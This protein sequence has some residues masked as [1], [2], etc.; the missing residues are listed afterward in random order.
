VTKWRIRD[1]RDPVL[2]APTKPVT[3]DDDINDL[4]EEMLKRV[5]GRRCVGIAANQLGVPLRTCVVFVEGRALLMINP[6]IVAKSADEEPADEGCLS[7]DGV[8]VTVYRPVSVRVRYEFAG[9]TREEDF[10]GF[11]ARVIQHEVDHLDGVVMTDRVSRS[12]R[13]RLEAQG[14]A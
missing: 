8:R 13:R 9:Q 7:F 4:L 14:K 5:D 1:F 10:F 11:D 2:K 6:V 12:V 3:L